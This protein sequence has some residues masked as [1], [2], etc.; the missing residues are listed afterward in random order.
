MCSTFRVLTRCNFQR[1][2]S[3][4]RFEGTYKA[5]VLKE[6][7]KDLSIAEQKRASLKEDEIRIQVHYCSVNS[8]D[9][10]YF[11]DKAKL[12][13]IPG[14]EFSGEVIEIGK[15]VTKDQVLLG[16]KVA[17]LSLDKFGALAEECVVRI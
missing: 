17:A 9:L 11:N 2:R 6:A 7:L 12:P 14:Y 5:A 16:E 3:Q 10:I 13:F 8:G 15:K 4:I 1:F